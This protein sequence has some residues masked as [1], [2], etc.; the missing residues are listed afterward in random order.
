MHNTFDESSNLSIIRHGIASG[1]AV[2]L[3]LLLTACQ[4]TPE[5]VAVIQAG[6]FLENLQEAPFE[7][8]EAPGHVSDR[9]TKNG[10]AITFDAEV[11]VPEA[12]AYSIVELEQVKYTEA[13]YAALM[14]FFVPGANWISSMQQTK[15]DLIEM[16]YRIQSSDRYTESEK[17]EHDRTIQEDLLLAPESVTQT[18]FDLAAAYAD[19]RGSA[20]YPQEGFNASFAFNKALGSWQYQREAQTYVQIKDFLTP[21]VTESD[22]FM[23]EDFDRDPE[24]TQE[25]ALAAAQELLRELKLTGFALY[26]AA[27]GIAYE[28]REPITYGWQFIFTRE[29]C[30]LQTQYEFQGWKTWKNSPPPAYVSPWNEEV[31]SVFVDANGVYTCGVR[32]LARQTEVLYENVALLPFDMLLERIERQMVYQHA[33]QGEGVSKQA[34]E[35]QSISLYLS[36]INIK[37]KLGYGMLIPSWTVEYI[38]SYELNGVE[39]RYTNSTIFNAIDGSYIEPRAPLET[40][41]RQTN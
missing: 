37:D 40:L 22:A 10:L 21:D 29:S 11:I 15:A 31:V 12:S 20:W 30:G 39:E 2:V 33:S 36:M 4:P 3:A 35:I 17:K 28:Y 32:G 18:P 8:Y 14:D 6:D 5:S 1:L 23:L 41:S 34:V 38:F 27:K 13:E 9:K 24:I 19:G 25:D 26:S 16:N 7:P